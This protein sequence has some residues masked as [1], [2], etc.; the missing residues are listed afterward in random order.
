MILDPT[1]KALLGG[2][3]SA[4]TVRSQFCDH[5]ERCP[6]RSAFPAR[7]NGSSAVPPSLA[8]QRHDHAPARPRLRPF[9]RG[10]AAAGAVFDLLLQS[11]GDI[12]RVMPAWPA[13]KAARFQNLR[14]G[15]LPGSAEQHGGSLKQ[16]EAKSTVGGCLR[17]RPWP[18]VLLSRTS[19]A[20]AVIG[21][22]VR[23]RRHQHPCR[24]TPAVF[25]L[26]ETASGTTE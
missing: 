10:F 23:N 11:V 25:R 14:P 1:E 19:A 12:L 18:G 3:S 13:E 8:A 22:P 24:R 21:P 9:H 17:S 6:V 16:V 7:G 26:R 2:P 20:D 4:G 15:P 5:H